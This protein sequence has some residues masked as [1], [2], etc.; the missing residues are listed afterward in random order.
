MAVLLFAAAFV[1]AI[2]RRE[3]NFG[4]FG[5]AAMLF[6]AAAFVAAVL[7]REAILGLS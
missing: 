2:L 7:R 3:A 5:I 6:F 4:T 1:A